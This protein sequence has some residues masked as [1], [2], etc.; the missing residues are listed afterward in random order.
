MSNIKIKY[1]TLVTGLEL[2]AKVDTSKNWEK[3]GYVEL[4]D[5]CFVSINPLADVLMDSG[6]PKLQI[7]KMNPWIRQDELT[8]INFSHIICIVNLDEIMEN[9]YQAALEQLKIKHED[10]RRNLKQGRLIKRQDIASMN[11][12]DEVDLEEDPT[13]TNNELF[14]EFLT[15][16][17][18]LN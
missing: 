18:M 8:R 9:F 1:L 5:P 2:I 13:D 7:S 3:L 12:E 14:N 11:E 4:I 17:K 16:K 15:K 6:T 10:A